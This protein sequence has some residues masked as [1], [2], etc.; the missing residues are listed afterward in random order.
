MAETGPWRLI[1]DLHVTE[2]V[3]HFTEDIYFTQSL[4]SIDGNHW[5][6]VWRR[7]SF[8]FLDFSVFCLFVYLFFISSYYNYSFRN[9]VTF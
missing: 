4:E 7:L 9:Q 2:D 1:Y 8:I 3:S 5:Q 6:V